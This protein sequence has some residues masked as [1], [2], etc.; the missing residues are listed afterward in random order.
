MLILSFNLNSLLSSANNSVDVGYGCR[1]QNVLVTDFSLMTWNLT[2][3][4]PECHQRRKFVCFLAQ[5]LEQLNRFQKSGSLNWIV[6][7]ICNLRIHPMYEQN[8]IKSYFTYLTN[9]IV[10]RI[11]DLQKRHFGTP[12]WS[13]CVCQQLP[14]WHFRQIVDTVYDTKIACFKIS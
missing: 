9:R 1:R 6:K 14:I 11:Y 2:W 5:I 7:P 13:M 12:F 3:N 4:F 10:K 8:L